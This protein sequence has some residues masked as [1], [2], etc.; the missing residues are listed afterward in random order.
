MYF[1]FSKSYSVILSSNDVSPI[2]E[3]EE[4]RLQGH[5][6]KML[7][8]K[9]TAEGATGQYIKIRQGTLKSNLTLNALLRVCESHVQSCN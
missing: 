5:T 6:L 4:E 8:F 7:I 2:E 1:E 3:E 9:T